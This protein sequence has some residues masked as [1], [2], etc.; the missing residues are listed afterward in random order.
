MYSKDRDTIDNRLNWVLQI[1]NQRALRLN[2]TVANRMNVLRRG[3]GDCTQQ[4]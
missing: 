4:E 2:C 3:L 1:D